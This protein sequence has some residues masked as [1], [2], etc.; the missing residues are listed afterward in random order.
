MMLWFKVPRHR[1]KGTKIKDKPLEVRTTNLL[2]SKNSMK[3]HL[4]YHRKL[5]P[6]DTALLS[7]GRL[8]STLML[9][10]MVVL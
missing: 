4:L 7:S 6:V 3:V 1:G 8:M 10:K 9:V 2:E 5:L